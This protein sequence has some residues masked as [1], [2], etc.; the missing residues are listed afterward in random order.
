MQCSTG[1]LAE[2]Y[3]FAGD[4][5]NWACPGP[6]IIL[7]PVDHCTGAVMIL[8]LSI[9]CCDDP[10]IINMGTKESSIPLIKRLLSQ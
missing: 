2:I 7:P 3:I 10:D 1:V 8:I 6:A 4:S 9:W 5:T